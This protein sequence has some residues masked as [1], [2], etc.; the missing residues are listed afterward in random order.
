MT[1][2]LQFHA[3]AATRGEGLRP[4]FL[5]L[6]KRLPSMVLLP[7]VQIVPTE[8]LDK[9]TL[10]A[11]AE[12][13]QNANGSLR[14]KMHDKARGAGVKHLGMFVDVVQ[15]KAVYGVSDKPM[16]AEEWKRQCVREG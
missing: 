15:M 3:L 12:V 6:F 9:A 10:D 16:S 14:I 8:E 7:R 11:I 2:F 4:E 13:S 5:D 1:P